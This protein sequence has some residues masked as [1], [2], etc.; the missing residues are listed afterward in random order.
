MTDYAFSATAPSDGPIL[1]A[2]MLHLVTVSGLL[3]SRV[4]VENDQLQIKQAV[5][6]T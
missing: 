3:D 6:D 4:M 2:V 5:A 1:A